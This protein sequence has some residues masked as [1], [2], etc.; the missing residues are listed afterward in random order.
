MALSKRLLAFVFVLALV[1]YFSACSSK[2]KPVSGDEI[3]DVKD[4]IELFPEPVASLQFGDTILV[5]KLKDTV[6]V[7]YK[8]IVKFV[9]DSVLSKVFGRNLKPKSYPLGRMEDNNKTNYLL[10]KSAAGETKAVL[11]FCFDKNE[12][13]VAAINLL[14]PD[15]SSVTTQSVSID[16]NFNIA[17][18]ISRRNADGSVSEGKDSYVLNEDAQT[19]TLVMTE[20]LDEKIKDQANP[21]DTFARKQKYSADY[22]SA[23]TNLV[24]IRD[25]K[26]AGEFEFFMRFEKDNGQCNGELKGEAKFT[27]KNTAE[28]REAGD[29]CVMRFVFS[30]SSVSIKEVEGC[31]SH[32]GLRCSFDGNYAKKKY[33]KP[34]K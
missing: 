15:A 11:L 6:S 29:P 13:L 28:Y 27:G 9:P 8:A 30:T 23:K 12:K 2:K 7:S 22:S 25:G 17:K 24:S 20:Q 4:F 34:K 5:K 31:G 10:M 19:F 3:A 21:I 33:I 14:K 26:K 18:N 16:R 32:R 1:C